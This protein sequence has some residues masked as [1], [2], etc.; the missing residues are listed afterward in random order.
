MTKFLLTYVFHFSTLETFV[1]TF[2]HTL[3]HHDPSNVYLKTEN[4]AIQ[5]KTWGSHSSPVGQV[6]PE[7]LKDSRAPGSNSTWLLDPETMILQNIWNYP[8]NNTASYP[9][10]LYSSM[11]FSF[12]GQELVEWTWSLCQLYSCMHQTLHSAVTVQ[13][14]CHTSSTHRMRTV[15]QHISYSNVSSLPGVRHSISRTVRLA[16]GGQLTKRAK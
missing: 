9:R 3:F 13:H 15:V 4:T 8:P 5:C 7:V 6:V 12:N 11:H 10:K 2:L 14:G 16:G 1:L